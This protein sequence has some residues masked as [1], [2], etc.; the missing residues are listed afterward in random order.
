MTASKVQNHLTSLLPTSPLTLRHRRCHAQPTH[1]VS[2]S[3]PALPAFPC[4][5][6]TTGRTHTWQ[7]RL[8]STI[9][10]ALVGE[11]ARPSHQHLTRRL[12][13]RQWRMQLRTARYLSIDVARCRNPPSARSSA[14][15]TRPCQAVYRTVLRS[16]R[17]PAMQLSMA[18]RYPLTRTR[19]S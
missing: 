4:E 13:V 3:V 15:A 9:P 7:L 8:R 6:P 14:A 11:R 17:D 10:I 5:I 18:R 16:L 1:I 12:L 2:R 19:R